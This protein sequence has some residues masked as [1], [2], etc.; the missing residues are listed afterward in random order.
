MVP[1][2]FFAD[3]FTSRYFPKNPP[4]AFLQDL[5]IA[6]TPRL[7]CANSTTLWVEWD[8]PVA[9][10]VGNSPDDVLE[11]TLYMRGGFCEWKVGDHVLVEYLSRAQR[12]A[13]TPE[14]NTTYGASDI[15]LLAGEGA[16]SVSWAVGEGVGSV[17]SGADQN[18]GTD[19]VTVKNKVDI[20]SERAQENSGGVEGTGRRLFPAVITEKGIG[21]GL[22]D[23]RWN[24]GEHEQGVRRY[25]IHRQ[26]SPL[27][28]WTVVYQGEKCSYAVEGMM[29]E[30]VVE[31]ELEFLYEAEAQFSLQ[32]K[33]TEVPREKLSRHSPVVTLRTSFEGQGPLQEGRG[34]GY[35]GA[36]ARVKARLASAKAPDGSVTP[37]GTVHS[38]LSGVHCLHG[39]HVAT[40][41][42]RLYL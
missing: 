13:V 23:I 30:S 37:P 1:L 19:I 22:F 17:S 42:G 4:Y 12:K 36:S 7:R 8:R 18:A 25:R 16:S 39:Q 32:S 35:I 33:G 5:T 6:P 34:S 41:K 24:D 31:R 40:G 27:P 26:A 28:S 38:S 10:A 14:S 15:G 20:S 11:Y 21:S 9:D 2:L 3:I 29:P